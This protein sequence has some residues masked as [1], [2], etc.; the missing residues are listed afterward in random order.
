MISRD[1]AFELLKNNTPEENLIHHA[2]ESEAVLK[3]LAE[4]LGKNQDKWALT[5]LLH[6]LDYSKT[7][8][9]PENHGLVSAK[10]LEEHLPQDSIKAIRAHNSELNGVKP[11]TDLDFALRCGETVTGLIHANALIR[12]EGMKGMTP[13]SLKKKM[14][15]KAFA[16]S[17]NRDIINECE[18]IGLDLGEFFTISIAAIE[19]IAPEV[20][21]E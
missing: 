21:L 9:V 18:H 15:A 12:P 5:G 6:D 7:C 3:A 4:K 14:K 19:K 16:A 8:N 11:D 2:L 1:D 13:K 17:V 20:G 10:I